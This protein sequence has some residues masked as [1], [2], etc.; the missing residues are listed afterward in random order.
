MT[1]PRITVAQLMVVVLLVALGL[2]QK[3]ASLSARIDRINEDTCLQGGNTGTQSS[4]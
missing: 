4:K 3:I 1:R 2:A